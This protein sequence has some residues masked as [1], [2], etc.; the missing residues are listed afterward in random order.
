MLACLG[1]EGIRLGC[2]YEL[3][4]ATSSILSGQFVEAL[5]IV[6]WP[7]SEAPLKRPAESIDALEPGQRR[8]GL[9]TIAGQ[10]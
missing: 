4:G 6:T 3:S 9:Q 1:R 8:H 10:G 5:A 7:H 2:G